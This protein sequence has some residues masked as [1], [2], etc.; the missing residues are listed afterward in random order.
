MKALAKMYKIIMLKED[1]D[2]GLTP[3]FLRTQLAD[4]GFTDETDHTYLSAK[5]QYFA[6]RPCVAH[7]P[8]RLILAPTS[9]CCLG[10]EAERHRRLRP[11]VSVAQAAQTVARAVCSPFVLAALICCYTAH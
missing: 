1:M 11:T 5:E 8:C 9:R 2:P 3:D 10:Q 4:A 6:V 7:L